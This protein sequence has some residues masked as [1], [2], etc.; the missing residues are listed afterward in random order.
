MN[1]PCPSPVLPASQ[2]IAK[3]LRTT[4]IGIVING[5]LATIKIAAG[6]L[7]NSYALIADGIE[8]SSDVVSSIV[9]FVGLKIA[10]RPATAKHP[11]GRGRAETLAAFIVSAA[12]MI[13]AV[14]ITIQ[15]I[16]EIITPH[17][18]PA[19]FTL[20]VLIAVI[21]AKEILFRV[22][23][24]R[25][26]ESQSLA[27]K[28][29]AWHHRSDAITSLAA[30]I[31]ISIALIGGPGYES[32]DD[33]AALV[34]AFVIGVS[35]VFLMRS[36]LGELT[37]RALDGVW[38]ERVKQIAQ[39][40]PGVEGTHRCWIRKHGFDLFVELDVIVDGDLTVR[41]GHEIAHQVYQAVRTELP[42]VRRV[43]IHVEPKDEHGR[44]RLEWE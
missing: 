32:A 36:A 13:A 18:A 27:V 40:V 7:G 42:V 37:D 35:S 43:L 6:V 29:D 30:F 21:L 11:F 23:L 28:T 4:G 2:H 31:G 25:A 38:V 20:V 44:F 41:A 24:K 10:A 8:S 12:L 15:S 26:E 22:A 16:H 5:T 17:H 3:A 39:T 9:T 33:W 34:A 14:A 19:A 1:L